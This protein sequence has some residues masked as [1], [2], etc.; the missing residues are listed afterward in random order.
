MRNIAANPSDYYSLTEIPKKS[1]G[2]RIISDPAKD[3]KI[4]QRRIVRRIFSNCSFPSYLFGSVKDEHNPRDFVRNA[5][6][7]VDAA[8]VIAFDID[9]FFPSVRPN[10]IKAIYKY[11]FNFPEEVCRILVGLTTLND[12]LPQGAPTSSYLANLVFYDC[13][14]KLVK[15][16]EAKGLRYTRLV[17]DISVSSFTHIAGST[18]TFVFNSIAALLAEKKLKIS[19]RKYKITSTALHG[20]KT[21]VTGLLVEDKKVKLPK[22]K[23]KAIGGLVYSLAKHAEV[24]RTD[25]KFHASFGK[26]SGQVALYSRLDPAKSL[27][28]RTALRTMMPIY[29]PAK[30]KKI[31]WLCR[32]FA[33][34]AK[35]HPH[36]VSEEGYAR[37]F[38]RYKH[39]I[40]IIRRTHRGLARKLAEQM[41]LY[42]PT[43]LLASYYE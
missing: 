20:E 17:D 3:L 40:N 35:A 33:N 25:P 10:F 29:A 11:L 28:Y 15:T 6:Y 39:K 22:N 32:N 19:K 31:S 30:V 37:K 43:R 38:Y 8:E 9:S 14:Y 5:Q 2:N 21:I 42:R 7:H 36:K 4:V 34:Y 23:V 12:G 26:A 16:L 13:E 24:D 18:R 27:V 41:D 1:G